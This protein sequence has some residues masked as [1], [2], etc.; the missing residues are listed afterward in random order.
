MNSYLQQ[1]SHHY[2]NKRPHMGPDASPST[3]LD[4]VVQQTPGLDSAQ[5]HGLASEHGDPLYSNVDSV[6]SSMAT[7]FHHGR[8]HHAD[9]MTNGDADGGHAAGVLGGEGPTPM[10]GSMPG[11]RLQGDGGRG[12]EDQDGD[13][14]EGEAAEEEDVP[15]TGTV[16]E[17]LTGIDIRVQSIEKQVRSGR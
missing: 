5:Q 1:Q 8:G 17:G 16:R 2:P 3:P 10:G 13:A 11:A 4:R 12:G 15:L 9:D 14:Q 6:P 7:M